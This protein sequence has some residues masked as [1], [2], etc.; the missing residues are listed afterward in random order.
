MLICQLLWA[1]NQTHP[2]ISFNLNEL[3][4]SVNHATVEHSLRANWVLKNAKIE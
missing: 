4:S 2:D 1:S 3:S